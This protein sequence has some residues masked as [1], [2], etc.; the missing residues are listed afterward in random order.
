M[1]LII[2]NSTTVGHLTSK[3]RASRIMYSSFKITTYSRM[4]VC[5][6]TIKIKCEQVLSRQS[7]NTQ[8]TGA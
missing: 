3:V 5:W 6:G 2:S 4:K 7:T 8:L 1:K